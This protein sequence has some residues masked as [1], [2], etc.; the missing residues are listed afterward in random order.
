[1]QALGEIVFSSPAEKRRLE[2]IVW[3][4]IRHLLELEIQAVQEVRFV[5][6]T[7]SLGRYERIATY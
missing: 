2:E 7:K 4:E 5:C 6:G 1:L 3:P